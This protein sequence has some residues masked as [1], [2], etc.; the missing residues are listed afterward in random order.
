M[1]RHA[2][3]NSMEKLSKQNYYYPV[4]T[5]APSALLEG[6]YTFYSG[7]IYYKEDGL[8]K[9]ISDASF[10]F[11]NLT[12]Q[13][14]YYYNCNCVSKVCVNQILF[15]MVDR[16]WVLFDTTTDGRCCVAKPPQVV[17]KCAP[18]IPEM[19]VVNG[20]IDNQ[21]ARLWT[22]ADF[23]PNCV[24]YNKCIFTPTNGSNLI[25]NIGST[26]PTISNG[27]LTNF[28][29]YIKFDIT[30]DGESIPVLPNHEYTF[31]ITAA[32]R[33]NEAPTIERSYKKY[34]FPT[35]EASFPINANG[36]IKADVNSLINN[37]NV[38]IR[39]IEAF[40]TTSSEPDIGISPS[41]MFFVNQPEPNFVKIA[42]I[43]LFSDATIPIKI[44]GSVQV[45]IVK[46]QLTFTT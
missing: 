27:I 25:R 45:N 3:S 46:K 11:Y 42:Y 6:E 24:V 13:K 39:S 2:L 44:Q 7:R 33:V 19:T 31:Q 29:D 40:L 10:Y 18:D 32:I 23:D 5:V 21:N 17:C 28:T 4:L 41:M 37:Q 14:L 16:E 22:L 36:V 35:Y 12:K 8:I 43:R 1:K 38:F 15:N 34:L 30:P 26:T 20:N 9:Q